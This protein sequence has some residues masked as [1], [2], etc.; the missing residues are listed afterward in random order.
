[1]VDAAEEVHGVNS[2]SQW[3]ADTARARDDAGVTRR[4]TVADDTR[5]QIDM[6]GNDYLGLRHDD[7]VLGVAVAAIEEFGAGTGAPRLLGGSAR[8]HDELEQALAEHV[9]TEAALV[10]STGYSANLAALTALADRD[11]LIVSDAHNHTS[12][13]DAASLADGAVQVVPHGDL[14]A[15]SDA[16]ARRS[17]PRA[18]IVVESI[19][20]VLGD[21]ADLPALHEL[22]ERH[23]AWLMVDEGHALGVMGDRGEGV[24]GALG[25]ADSDRVI[26][27][28]SLSKALASQG[29]AV[30][31]SRML[32]SH[33]INSAHSFIDDTGLAPASAGSALGA[34]EV[35]QEEPSL[36][37]Q[38]HVA[39]AR[40]AAACHAP[41]PQGP[42]VSVPTTDLHK[43]LTIV[44]VC[45]AHG[46]RIGCVRPPLSPDGMP[47]LRLT[48]HANLTDTD[49]AFS[50]QTLRSAVARG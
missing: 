12:I 18:L 19:F 48:A 30:L 8:V 23:D 24:L 6:V 40:I 20:S 43:A 26:I 36:V 50:A 33:L 41:A 5:G 14:D 22:A 42:I 21:L 45:A 7:R 2:L 47:R 3:L 4:L 44:D 1:M 28:A 15:V 29:G 13:R 37:K 39:A 46:I 35:L 31:G 49:L 32:R 17:R 11:T 38:V 25:L 34:L 16:L 9:G 10:F 27:T